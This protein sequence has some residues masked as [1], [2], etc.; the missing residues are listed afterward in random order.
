MSELAFLWM[1]DLCAPKDYLERFE[2][3]ETWLI[4]VL[5]AYLGGLTRLQSQ[6]WSVVEQAELRWGDTRALVPTV[7]LTVVSLPSIPTFCE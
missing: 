5:E 1:N 6:T 3:T 2:E 4:D 7:P